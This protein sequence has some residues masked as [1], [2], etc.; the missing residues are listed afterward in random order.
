RLPTIFVGSS[1]GGWRVAERGLS[2]KSVVFDIGVGEDASFARGLIERFALTVHAFDPTPRSISCV[3]SQTWPSLFHFYPIWL[4]THDGEL[5]LHAPED[6]HHV[7]HTVVGAAGGG[8]TITVPVHRL[9]TLLEMS[10]ETKIDLLK[11]DVEGAE[12]DVIEDLAKTELR[13][14]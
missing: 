6:P 12:Y 2:G 1:Y 10:G 3:G 7:S 11:M 14:T 8:H 4:S 5:R 13:P 9:T